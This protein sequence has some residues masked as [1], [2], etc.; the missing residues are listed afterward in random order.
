MTDT[1]EALRLAEWLDRC[2][3]SIEQINAAAMLRT[4]AAEVEALRAAL[5]AYEYAN[6]RLFVHCLSNGV[7]NAWGVAMDCTALND[8]ALTQPAPAPVAEAPEVRDARWWLEAIVDIHK[9]ADKAPEHRCYVEGAF[10]DAI[11]G[12]VA[13]L[14]GPP[15]PPASQP[16]PASLSGW[17]ETIGSAP[18]KLDWSETTTTEQPSQ[19]GDQVVSETLHVGDSMFEHWFSEYDMAHKG[20]KQQMRDAYAAGMG[21][22][23]HAA[24]FLVATGEVYEGQETYTRHEG[25]PPPLCDSEALYT[26]PPKPVPM[27]RAEVKATMTESGYD[28]ATAQERADFING[29]RHAEIHH[30][31]SKGE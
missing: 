18:V 17:I 13:Y 26:A 22:T 30:I 8:A 25:I 29:I 4:L 14:Q 10:G 9:D 1:K 28:Q 11:A 31:T 21:D 24:V 6:D 2:A 15:S 19:A 7:F 3:E 12:A 16:T 20:T 27:T 23:G 5:M